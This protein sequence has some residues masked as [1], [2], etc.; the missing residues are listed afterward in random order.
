MTDTNAT[1][2]AAGTPEHA[3]QV[4]QDRH[5]ATAD[6]LQWLTTSH[7]PPQL[8]PRSQVFYY[9]ATELILTNVDSAELTKALNALTEAKDWAIRAGIRTDTGRAGSIPRPQTVVDPPV[10]FVP[11][12]ELLDAGPGAV[13]HSHGQHGPHVHSA[14]SYARHQ[15]PMDREQVQ[16]QVQEG[17]VRLTGPDDFRRRATEAAFGQAD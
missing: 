16:A 7:L 3:A 9:A 13:L 1:E 5:Q 12:Q 11:D 2:P 15:Q 8:Q 4:T 17:Q 14:L 10:T 6:A